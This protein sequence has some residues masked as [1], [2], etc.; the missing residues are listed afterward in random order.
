MSNMSYCRFR[1]TLSDLRDCANNFYDDELSPEEHNARRSLIQEMLDIL[2]GIGAEIDE[3]FL[4][5]HEYME[6]KKVEY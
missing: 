5:D 6:K 4:E 3:D 2:D 1:N